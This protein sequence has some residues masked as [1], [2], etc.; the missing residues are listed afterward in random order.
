M[1]LTSVR[2][3]STIALSVLVLILPSPGATDGTTST[4][5]FLD[6]DIEELLN[7]EISVASK[8]AE[9]LTEAP[10]IVSVVPRDESVLFGDR[11]LH[12]LLQR[13]P[14]VY[15]R[16]SFVYSDNLA[17]FRGD[18]VTH[19]EMH[20]LVLFN[21]RPIRESAQSHNVNMY[22]AFPLTAL[23]SV[24]LVRGPGSVLYGSNAFTGV[25]NLKSRPI[26]EQREF[27]VSTMAGSYEDFETT[28]SAGGRSGDLGIVADVRAATQRG[29]TY[30]LADQ[31]GV[32]GEDNKFD[33]SVSAAAHL[34]YKNFTFDVFGSTLDAFSMGVFPFWSNPNH[35]IDNKKL[36]MNAGYRVPVHERMTLELN[37]TYNLQEN[38][39]SSS[40]PAM[41]GTNTSDLLGEVTLLASPLDNLNLV[42]GG[43][44][45]YRT[46]Y[47]PGADHF[48]S[49][50]PYHYSPK[51][52][53]AQADYSF[54]EVVKVIGGTQWNESSQGYSGFVNRYGLILTPLKKWGLKLLRGE[55]FRA[56]VTLESDLFDPRGL[57]GNKNLKP[58]TITTYDAQ[59]FYSDKKLYAAVTYFH[60]TID[61]LIIY[62]ASVVP[63]SYMNG[64]EQRFEGIEFETKYFLT[65]NCYLLGSFMHQENE[66]DAGLNP[67]VAPNNMAKVGLGYRWDGGSAA[68]FYGYFDDPPVIAS[69]VVVNPEPEAL[70]LLCLNVRVDTSKWIG[71]QKE[72]AILT[73]RA[74]NVLNQ[75][76]YVPTFAYTG[77]P[78][79]FPY[80]PGIAFYAGLTVNF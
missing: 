68:V 45:E 14:S 16:N 21:G 26:P 24:E 10:S 80:G 39:L 3:F 13:Q 67:T 69:P 2:V 74:E 52:A 54:N 38:R 40:D 57:V 66:A 59:L 61:G 55:A 65:P 73:L 5:D 47:A 43:L 58:E 37:A 29:F 70:H 4:E 27:S 46:N 15:T 30:R 63:M 71:L 75:E 23:D 56:P 36:F 19:A 42:V 1:N 62:D 35:Y 53:Y 34:D 25:I 64:G 78:N 22:T 72:R 76:V 31:A 49:I 9:P 48:Q 41:I 79:S 33:R 50:P 18:M 6:M 60:S 44:Q 51:S 7:V 8:K 32:Y 17:G 12:Q 28:I 77:A 11:D 20:T